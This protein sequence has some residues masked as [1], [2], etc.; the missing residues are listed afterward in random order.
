V[1]R[2]DERRIS[3]RDRGQGSAGFKL[4]A[5]SAVLPV[6]EAFFAS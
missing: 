4:P 6:Q 1:T 3:A 2:Q 5:W